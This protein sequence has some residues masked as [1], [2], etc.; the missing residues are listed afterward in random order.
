M[1]KEQP[2]AAD[3]WQGDIA[4]FSLDTEAIQGAGYSFDEG[5]LN[6]QPKQLPPAMHLKLTEVVAQEIVRHRMKPVLE[7]IAR[8]EEASRDRAKPAPTCSASTPLSVTGTTTVSPSR[9]MGR[10]S[11]RKRLSLP[12]HRQSDHRSDNSPTG[13][14][15]CPPETGRE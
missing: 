4:F 11:P 13:Q 14:L 3:V 1:P 5:P 8:F 12:D 15:H 10:V 6:L 7:A 9:P 2:T